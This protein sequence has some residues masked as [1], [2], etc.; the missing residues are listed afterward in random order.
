VR[1]NLA[2]TKV[3]GVVTAYAA[4]SEPAS[5]TNCTSTT[6]DGVV[7]KQVDPFS[8]SDTWT[9]KLGFGG[10]FCGGQCFYDIAIA[11]SPTNASEVY[12]G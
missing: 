10:G 8:V 4:T 6:Q 9:T 7:R 3:G 5:G 2:M 1:L 11:V 12:L